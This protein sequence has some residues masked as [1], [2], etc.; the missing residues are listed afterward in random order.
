MP[1]LRVDSSSAPWGNHFDRFSP[2]NV[3]TNECDF[4][5]PISWATNYFVGGDGIP[6]TFIVLDLGCSVFVKE[7]LLKNTHN[8]GANK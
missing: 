1:K 2:D 8:G 7:I 3:L 6:N 5:D 4:T